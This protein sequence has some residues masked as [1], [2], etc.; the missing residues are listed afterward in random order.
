MVYKYNPELLMFASPWSPPGW[1]KYSGFMDRGV[2]FPEKNHLKDEP[3]IHK[4]YALYF[5]KYVKVYAENEI[6]INRLIIQNEPDVHTKYPSCVMPP[7][8][9][10]LFASKYLN[11]AFKKNKVKTEIWAGTFR[12]AEQ[13]DAVE[14]AA[15]KEFRK[16]VEGIGFQ[17]TKPRYNS[18][19]KALY[20][21][22][23]MMHTEG[24]CFNGDNSIEQAQK[25]LEEV[26]SYINFGS[27]NYCYWNMI[28]NETGKSG[29]DWKQN[30]LI[31][32]DRTKQQVIYNPDYAVIA[33]ISKFL[34]PGAIRIAGFSRSE[35]ISV[36]KEGKVYL[37]VQNDTDKT[38]H[39]ECRIGEQKTVVEIPANSVASIV[40]SK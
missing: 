18:D 10:G 20:P 34:Q 7:Q 33:L 9:M 36:A 25:R 1:M 37:L 24:N 14:F 30:S 17:Y 32:I 38:D 5:S 21:D 8:Q 13:L 3:K 12:T 11:Q 19:M 16:S 31:N 4:A 29:W 23:K 26:A 28:L 22:V 2:E 6:K 15:N 27:P 39:Y 35:L 40:L